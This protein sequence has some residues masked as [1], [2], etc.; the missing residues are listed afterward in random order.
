MTNYYDNLPSE[1]IV[2]IESFLK[3]KPDDVEKI[4]ENPPMKYK[5]MLDSYSNSTLIELDS[6]FRY[7]YIW[8]RKTQG[9]I[10]E[11][12][13]KRKQVRANLIKFFIEFDVKS[14]PKWSLSDRKAK[15]YG[16]IK[17]CKELFALENIIPSCDHVGEFTTNDKK[18]IILSSPYT[19]DIDSREEHF[20][21]GFKRYPT[22][23]YNDHAYTY[24]LILS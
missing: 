9:E 3:I 16:L 21:Y 11:E 10:D 1:L 4:I 24:V 18:H 22:Y 6:S 17:S 14:M 12:N 5:K 2:Q 19:D 23:L 13:T 7:P 20:K 8:R 15:K